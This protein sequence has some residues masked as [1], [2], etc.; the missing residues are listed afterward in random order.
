MR[1]PS[2]LACFIA[3]LFTIPSISL[4]LN[5]Q[6]SC[7]WN[8]DYEQDYAIGITDI[9]AILGVFGATDADQ[10]GLWDSS[11]LCEDLEACN[12]D[13]DPT[14]PCL[15]EDAF[16]VCG[17]EGQIPELL[18]GTWQFS[19]AAGA[20]QVGP[21]PYSNDWFSSF[22][23]G[24][25]NAQYDDLYTFHADGTISMD[26]AG[27]II[28]AFS[29]YSEQAYGC[30]GVAMEFLPEG[31]T[32]GEPAFALLPDADAC[33]CP[34]IG[35]NDGGLVY[36]I[37]SLTETSLALHAQ[38]DDTNC[39]AAGLYF[40]YVFTRV[41][42]GTGNNDESGEGYPAAEGYEGMTLVWSDEF[43]ETSINLDNWTYDLGNNGWGN[44]EWQNYTNS[45][46]NSSVADGF[47]TIT[48]RQEG[49]GYTSA[50]LK[51][52]GLQ[53]FQYGRMDI[54]AKLPE[55]QGIWPALWMLGENFTSVGWPA[56]GEIDIMELIGHEPST[57]HG[58]AHWGS[59]WNVHQYDGASITL[60]NGEKF[61][62]EF[63]L[64]SVVWEEN[65]V[66]WL[67]DDQPYYSINNT[68]MNGQP[69]PFNA[70]FF[71]IMNVAVG[72]NWPGYPDA[73][74]QFPQQMVVDCV[75]VFQ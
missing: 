39:N 75:R 52:Q 16:G 41:G 61:S 7:G 71:F 26:Y 30:T 15:Y 11:D 3:L 60:P 65:Q 20:I 74:T 48:A 73:S 50:R 68:Q 63:H 9:L 24:L 27:T 10:D 47:L 69:Y 43:D 49:S 18:I 35:T 22:A 36:D 5:A 40:T 66:T 17:G 33:T 38:G 53:S 56:C 58:T 72:G 59:N 32:S 4:G 29:D 34:F 57:V 1:M 55:G 21:D 44:N 42:D 12:Y 14:E 70:P 25:Q 62:D 13:A 64:F 2:I 46:T 67:M 6:E 23:L 19:T 54:R 37:V 31:G 8:P 45:S 51:S 28:D